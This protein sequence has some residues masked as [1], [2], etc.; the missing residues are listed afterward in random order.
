MSNPP[1]RNYVRQVLHSSLDAG[2]WQRY[3][4]CSG[5]L[6][7][8]V[9]A[10]VPCSI[11]LRKVV[12]VLV[13]RRHEIRKVKERRVCPRHSVKFDTMQRTMVGQ[14]GDT[15][16]LCTSYGSCSALVA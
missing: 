13:D 3:G 9:I 14:L 5:T 12:A 1:C 4:L 11:L 8:T 10:P 2:H 16:V 7:P 15:V 6:R